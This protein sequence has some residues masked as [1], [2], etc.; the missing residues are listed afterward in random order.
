ML[1]NFIMLVQIGFKMKL[2]DMWRV[3]MFLLAG[4]IS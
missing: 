2:L 4:P 1:A 3:I